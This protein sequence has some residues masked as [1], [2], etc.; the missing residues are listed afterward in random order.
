MRSRMCARMFNPAIWKN[1]LPHVLRKDV[2]LDGPPG[3]RQSCKRSQEK[4]LSLI[5]ATS[6]LA[7]A[8]VMAQPG[9]LTR[10]LVCSYLTNEFGCRL[11]ATSLLYL[12]RQRVLS[13]C[14]TDCG[15]REL[16]SRRRSKS[17]AIRLPRYAVER[18][19]VRHSVPNSGAPWPARMIGFTKID[20]A[21]RTNEAD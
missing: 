10:I 6:E 13:G 19:K 12:Q 11:N 15:L 8:P 18:V 9:C 17:T 14:G 7:S 2:D 4:R 1:T 3:W 21:G 20:L 16:A 5:R